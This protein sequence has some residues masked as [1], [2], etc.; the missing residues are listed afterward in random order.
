MVRFDTL[1]AVFLVGAIVF[2]MAAV[3]WAGTETVTNTFE[4][5]EGWADSG[6]SDV[7]RGM[8]VTAAYIGLIPFVIVAGLGT[9][10]LLASREGA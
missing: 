3:V 6:D 7:D 2:A 10:A 1:A 9:Y 5:V 8:T 4:Q